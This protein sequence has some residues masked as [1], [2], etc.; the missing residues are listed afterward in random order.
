[1][2]IAKDRA[3][4]RSEAIII[5]HAEF[6]SAALLESDGYSLSVGGNLT[7][8]QLVELDHVVD[9]AGQR[10]MNAGELLRERCLD[11]D[12]PEYYDAQGIAHCIEN[13]SPVFRDVAGGESKGGRKKKTVNKKR[14]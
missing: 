9:V 3:I 1:M 7:A 5:G 8:K 12:D 10:G 2:A 11:E 4:L 13:R 14:M 6:R